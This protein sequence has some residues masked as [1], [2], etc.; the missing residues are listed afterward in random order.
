VSSIVDVELSDAPIISCNDV[1]A[2]PGD[3]DVI[4]PCSVTARPQV[5]SL[6]WTVSNDSADVTDVTLGSN[7]VTLVRVC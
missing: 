5:T 4:L 7:Y 2:T 3:I 1:T 6:Y